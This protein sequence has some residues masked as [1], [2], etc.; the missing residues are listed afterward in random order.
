[1]HGIYDD[2]EII[3]MSGN[4]RFEFIKDCNNH[5]LLIDNSNRLPAL[6]LSVD[7]DSL[8]IEDWNMLDRWLE[9]L[10]R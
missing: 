1:M 6:P 7:Y 2:R 8:T 4:Q 5:T 9:Y 10:N 3:K